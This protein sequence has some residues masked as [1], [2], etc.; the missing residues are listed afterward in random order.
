MSKPTPKPISY[1]GTFERSMDVKNRVTIP[2]AWLNGGPNAF[3]AIPG[4]TGDCLIVMPPEEFDSIESRIEQ[5]GAPA[6]ERRKAIRQ[7]YSQARAI[8][9]D[10]NGRILLPDDH[11]DSVKLKGE[12]VL[13]G[14]RSRFEIWNA[15]RWAA[16]SAE[17]S[18]SYRQVAELIGL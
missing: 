6:P 5:S 10:S 17:E 2:A 14:G 9:A 11:C 3:H 16:V 8:S 4:P 15:K 7:F 18:S 13:V 1:A 12:V